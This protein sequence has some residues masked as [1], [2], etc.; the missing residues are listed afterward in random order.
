[1]NSHEKRSDRTHIREDS[2]GVEIREERDRGRGAPGGLEQSRQRKLKAP[3]K[4]IQRFESVL[5]FLQP[6]CVISAF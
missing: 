1:M 3:N 5:L 4:A 6:N 2:Y